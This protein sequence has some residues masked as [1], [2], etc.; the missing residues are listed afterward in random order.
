MPEATK[1]TYEELWNA[2]EQVGSGTV[3]IEGERHNVPEEIAE[4]A[5]SIVLPRNDSELQQ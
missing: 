3:F 1:P 5:D 2:L 4:W